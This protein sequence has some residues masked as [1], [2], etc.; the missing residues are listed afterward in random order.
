MGFR[1]VTLR[2]RLFHAVQH[3]V[4]DTKHRHVHEYL[5]EFLL[6]FTNLMFLIGSVC[7]L[8][9]V[10]FTFSVF[11][12]GDWLFIVAAFVQLA[13]ATQTLHEQFVAKKHLSLKYDERDRHEVM[14]TCFF[15][16]ACFIFW[17]GS[18]FF[19]PGIYKTKDAE[20]IGK[21]IG[22]W[23]FVIGSM[24]LVLA[25]YF[26]ALGLAAE[27]AKHPEDHDNEYIVYK[28]HCSAL[29]L[30]QLG[31]V[32]FACGSFL[33]RP[34]FQNKCAKQGE[35]IFDTAVNSGTILYIAGSL[36]LVVQS[37]LMLIAAV[38][39]HG[40]K[41][42]D[43]AEETAAASFKVHRLGGSIYGSTTKGG[44]IEV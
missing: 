25:T 8:E 16:I 1:H 24:G 2:Q 36:L 40:G 28:L 14:E 27:R 20:F 3:E 42:S 17:V 5:H 32:A 10:G 7:F 18:V 41:R 44:S 33:Y 4:D 26:N 15:F 11:M 23:G 22:S 37:L 43:D 35:E 19:M 21:E 29:C 38:L 12:V 31:G 13:L 30:A 39:K 34:M 6:F 9:G